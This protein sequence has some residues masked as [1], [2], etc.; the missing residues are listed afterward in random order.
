MVVPDDLAG[1]LNIVVTEQE[2]GLQ[3][4]RS[5]ATPASRGSRNPEEDSLAQAEFLG[6]R[7]RHHAGRP[8]RPRAT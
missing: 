2:A 7:A 8:T 6:R 5:A 3:P 4:P 1:T